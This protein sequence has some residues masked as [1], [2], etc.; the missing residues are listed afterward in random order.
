MEKNKNQSGRSMVEM[1]GVLAVI[2]VLSV[3]GIYGYQ[4]AMNRLEFNNFVEDL[5]T[6]V[7]QFK[8]ADPS[9]SRH[10]VDPTWLLSVK[11]G[12][13][14]PKSRILQAAVSGTK[15]K[16]IPI[17]MEPSEDT[18]MG[19][20]SCICVNT[21][22]NSNQISKDLLEYVSKETEKLPK[23]SDFIVRL[24]ASYENKG[25]SYYV[26]NACTPTQEGMLM[27]IKG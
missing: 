14:S 10:P 22:V 13:Y 4:T 8:G 20:P 19:C 11:L 21:S 3:G 1:L 9:L 16:K 7:Y 6:A 17:Y 24:D 18:V 25:I 23:M 2:G 27:Y 12:S 5:K 26:I 15:D